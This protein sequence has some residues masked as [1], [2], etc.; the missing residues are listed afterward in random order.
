MADAP[1]AIP[2]AASVGPRSSKVVPL[3]VGLYVL[4]VLSL[5]AALVLEPALAGAVGRRAISPRWLFLPIGVYG[6]FYLVYAADRLWVLK[7]RRF[8]SARPF[9]EIFFGLI[10]GSLL[11]PSTI[12][13]YRQRPGAVS[14]P[15][16]ETAAELPLQ[17]TI[18]RLLAHPDAETRAVAIDAVA[19][20]G[21][22]PENAALLIA[23]LD[24]DDPRV[25]ARAL[26]VLRG[27]AGDPK[28]DATGV[29]AWASALSRTSTKSST[30]GESSR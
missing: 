3:R 29:R 15:R 14:E 23:R 4:T 12:A 8:R 21:P 2:G 6:L 5:M 22:T 19:Y 11:L 10:F 28:A 30:V 18:Q 25:R 1:T 20:R 9:F 27:W 7:K 13:H 17:P 26:R 16:P 24:D